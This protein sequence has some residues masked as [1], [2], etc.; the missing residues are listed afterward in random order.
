MSSSVDFNDL[1]NIEYGFKKLSKLTQ[2]PVLFVGSGLSK[3]YLNSPTWKEL[4]S[5]LSEKIGI[6]N[7]LLL[8]GDDTDYEEI[9]ERLEALYFTTLDKEDLLRESNIKRPFRE[10][11][12]SVFSELEINTPKY[13]EEIKLLRS[14]NYQKLIT[15]NYDS[16][17]EEHVFSIT[18]DDIY[19]HND[20]LFSSETKNKKLYKIHGS[21][22][23]PESIILT[24]TDYDQFFE[25][26]KYIYSKLLTMFVESPI[27]FLGYSVSDRNIKDILSTLTATLSQKEL[28]QFEDRVYIISYSPDDKPEYFVEK[29][30]LSL[31]NGSTISVNI[32]YLRTS[33][34][35]LYEVLKNISLKTSSLEFSVS[36][37]DVVNHF[38]IPLYKGQDKPAVVMRELLQNSMDACKMVKKEYEIEI[39]LIE[40]SDKTFLSILDNGVGMSID[41]IQN[42]YLTIGKSSKRE[43]K[44]VENLVGHFGIGALSMFLI[45]DEIYVQTKKGGDSP[46]SFKMYTDLASSNKEVQNQAI[47]EILS[48]ESYTFVKL[49]LKEEFSNDLKKFTE[50]EDFLDYFGLSDVILDGAINFSIILKGIEINHSFKKLDLGYFKCISEEPYKIHMYNE[51]KEDNKED[52]LQELDNYALY[53]DMLVKVDYGNDFFGSYKRRGRP[54]PLVDTSRIPLVLLEKTKDIEVP[55]NRDSI[56]LPDDI[57]T[58][59][60]NEYCRLQLPK[61]LGELNSICNNQQL[62]IPD[63]YSGPSMGYGRMTVNWYVKEGKVHIP[64]STT[65]ILHILSEKTPDLVKNHFFNNAIITERYVA[66]NSSNV[67][68]SIQLGG[69][70]ALS[71]KYI[72]DNLISIRS[73]NAGFRG[74]A[75]RKILES[76][77]F[78]NQKLKKL[79][80]ASKIKNFVMENRLEIAEFFEKQYED[81]ILWFDKK[82]KGHNFVISDNEYLYISKEKLKGN[83]NVAILKDIMKEHKYEYIVLDEK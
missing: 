57:A 16:L 23:K 59:I 11:I 34:Q 69:I 26:S 75:I 55:L 30:D 76:F 58:L 70:V 63:Y 27:V 38:I 13:L 19:I 39:S 9:A 1:K 66:D 2:K 44:D 29:E 43:E 3:R 79:K 4:L 36:K 45:S 61:Y 24:R 72:D 46:I 37:N 80:T 42:Y 49:E 32:F 33:Y 82:Y 50:I 21:V 8:T 51:K 18:N 15:T 81:N 68:S 12:S 53:G 83:E 41:D 25:K 5:K 77:D 17:L 31:L 6:D 64:T 35:E 62:P 22:N 65:E 47:K 78:P 67:S 54:K 60:E 28:K 74:D 73:Q 20:D 7:S 71:R 14:I 56:I 40:E 10:L 48:G 52:I